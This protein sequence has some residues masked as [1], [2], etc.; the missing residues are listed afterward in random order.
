MACQEGVEEVLKAQAEG[1]DVTCE[2]CTHYLYFTT[3][4]LDAIGPV[5]KCSPP[6]RDADQQA[7]LW[8]HVQTGGIAFVTSDHSPCTPDLKIQPML[9]KLGAAF[10]VFKIT[11]TCYLMKPSKTW[12]ILETIRG[13][14]CSKP[15]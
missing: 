7:A 4:E 14:D 11:S 3:D 2:T 6:I 10:L 9:L 13:Y 15:S 5:V 8:N 1:V 12:F